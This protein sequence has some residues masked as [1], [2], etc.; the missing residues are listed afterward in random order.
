MKG[1]TKIFLISIVFAIIQ[2]KVNALITNEREAESYLKDMNIKL[3]MEVKKVTEA[4]WNYETNITEANSEA[5]VRS[6]EQYLTAYWLDAISDI[7]RQSLQ[8]L[9]QNCCHRDQEV[10]LD[11]FQRIQS[12]TTRKDV[13]HRNGCSKQTRFRYRLNHKLSFNFEKINEKLFYS[14]HEWPTEWKLF[15]AALKSVL[16]IR[17]TSLLTLVRN[18][19]HFY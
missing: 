8:R 19:Y 5:R 13:S 12:K 15:I 1:L 11:P 9:L 10:W 7:G 18:N 16:K 14:T 17:V 3:A 6:S 2:S 4:A